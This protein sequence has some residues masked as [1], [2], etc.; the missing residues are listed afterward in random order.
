MIP[1]PIT[2][3]WMFG[4]NVGREFTGHINGGTWSAMSYRLV[5]RETGQSLGIALSENC[6]KRTHRD[7]ELRG[8][9]IR[10]WHVGEFQSDDLEEALDVLNAK[11]AGEVA[12]EPPT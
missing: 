5:D 4:G 11:R 8:R 9:C 7:C 12:S 6:Y 1:A 2:R 10:T 3:E